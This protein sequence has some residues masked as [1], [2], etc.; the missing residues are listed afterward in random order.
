MLDTLTRIVR[1]QWQTFGQADRRQG[2][3]DHIKKELV[4]VQNFTNDPEEWVDLWF[5]ATHGLW[6]TLSQMYPGYGS[7]QL[8]QLMLQGIEAKASK[9]EA[10]NWP[11]RASQD[12]NKAVEH[13]RTP[14]EEQR[15]QMEAI[16][17]AQN[18]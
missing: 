14:A 17:A 8:A 15:K 4:E 3:I 6:Q 5:M 7:E 13:I 16:R 9:N 2:I 18:P 10:R 11:D 1:W 12:P